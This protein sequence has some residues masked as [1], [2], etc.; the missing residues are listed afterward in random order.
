MFMQRRSQFDKSEKWAY[1]AYFVSWCV[2]GSPSFLRGTTRGLRIGGSKLIQ[3]LNWIKI[4]L[5]LI[6]LTLIH[7]T[8][9]SDLFVRDVISNPTMRTG[10][11]FKSSDLIQ[12]SVLPRTCNLERIWNL[13][14]SSL[15]D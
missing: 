5:T 1:L 12:S 13:V 15:S 8:L 4:H 9:N 6:H 11:D 3:P 10:L 2:V 14:Q 7:L